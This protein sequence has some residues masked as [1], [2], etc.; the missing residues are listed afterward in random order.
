[1]K[2]PLPLYLFL[3]LTAFSV[4]SACHKSNAHIDGLYGQWKWVRTDWTQGPAKGT[5]Y[6]PALS[7]TV[8]R[9]NTN[10][11][12]SITQN[13]STLAANTYSISTGCPNGNCDTIAAFK[14]QYAKDATQGYYW[15]VGNYILSLQSDTLVLTYDG[16]WNPGGGTSTQYFAAN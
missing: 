1:M 7:K 3:C 4:L 16:P 2:K 11:T 10:G 12:F 5:A 8:L 15:V 9:L 6:P 14:N 13:G